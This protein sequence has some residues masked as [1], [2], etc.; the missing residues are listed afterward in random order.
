[1]RA[2]EG[3]RRRKI[4][5]D[6]ATTNSWPCA[7]CVRL[8]LTCVPPTMSYDQD[9]SSSS[10]PSF[11]V[12]QNQAYMNAAPAPSPNEA[13]Q[14]QHAVPQQSA[15]QLAP[16]FAPSMPHSTQGG[17]TEDLRLYQQAPYMQMPPGQDALQ[18]NTSTATSMPPPEQKYQPPPQFSGPGTSP[19]SATRSDGVYRSESSG[20]SLADVLGE[21][22]ID[23]VSVGEY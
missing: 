22:K 18:Y 2:C 13:F 16:G 7:A 9:M 10:E 6:A 5:C 8:K 15:A 19:V 11:S 4:K 1:M 14:A 21:L 20:D 17:Y 3:C 23:H 12:D